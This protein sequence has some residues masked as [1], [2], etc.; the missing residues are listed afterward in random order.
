MTAT[1]AADP[2]DATTCGCPCG[3]TQ[4]TCGLHMPPRDQ[5]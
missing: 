2:E 4:R 1:L 5:R 3:M